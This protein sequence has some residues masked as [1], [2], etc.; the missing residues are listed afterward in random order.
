MFPNIYTRPHS[1]REFPFPLLSL[2]GRAKFPPSS[3]RKI[4]PFLFRT[5]ADRFVRRGER[6]G[7]LLD[8]SRVWE[9]TGDDKN[10]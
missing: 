2:P 7:G 5:Q 10:G 1:Q 3:R 9:R 4:E 6:L 8:R